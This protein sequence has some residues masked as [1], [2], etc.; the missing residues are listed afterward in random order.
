MNGRPTCKPLQIRLH[1]WLVAI[2]ATSFLAAQARAEAVAEAEFAR[3][4]LVLYGTSAAQ[5]GKPPMFPVDSMVTTVLQSHLEWIG[6][7]LDY[8]DAGSTQPPD[9]QANVRAIIVDGSLHVAVDR[10][11]ALVEWLTAQKKHGLP[12][13]LLGGLPVES[14]QPL[15]RFLA[16]FGIGGGAG[17]EHHLKEVSLAVGDGSVVSH[18]TELKARTTG[19]LN[20]LAPSNG[21]ALLSVL[22]GDA[23]GGEHRFDAVFTAPWGMAWMSPYVMLEVGANRRF[24]YLDPFR[25]IQTWLGDETFPAPDTTTQSGRRLFFSHIDGD[26]FA[27]RS[28]TAGGKICAEVMRDRV[29]KAHDLPVTVSVIEA[30]VC[31]LTQSLSP[32]NRPRYEEIARSIFSLPNVSPA[33]HSYSH[34]FQW[35]A[36]DPNPGRY[37]AGS[38]ALNEAADYKTISIEREVRGSV[39]YINSTLLPSGKKVEIMLWSGNC[40][41]GIEAL[42]LTRELGIENMNGGDTVMSRMYPSLSAVAP[43]LVPWGDELQIYAANQNEFMYTNGMNG[44]FSSGFANVV[45][46]FEST[47]SPR[48]LKPINLYYHFYSAASLSAMRALEKALAWCEKQALHGITAAQ[49]AR[50]VRDAHS[51]Q[52]HRIE[53]GKWRLVSQGDL[54]TWRLPASAGVPDIARCKN[55]AG[56][57]AEGDVTYVHTNGGREA[58]LV[59]APPSQPV[60]AYLHLRDAS[61]PILLVDQKARRLSFTVGGRS[62]GEMVIAG[63]P[64]GATCQLTR[65]DTPNAKPTSHAADAYGCVTLTVPSG[66]QAEFAVTRDVAVR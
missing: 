16:E 36:A 31:G 57:K 7:E 6:Y 66:M 60:A 64:P 4:I 38:L 12:I 37:E 61:V 49:Y 41:P 5:S 22:G 29:L 59:L 32:D 9:P 28:K 58:I 53:P 1:V 10:E 23:K 33:S 51:S 50:I 3:R 24:Y 19:F 13:L 11:D 55:I 48:R 17:A 35:D 34:P 45:D 18:E 26:G 39:N 65:L 21:K 15:A 52:V 43:R 2:C 8:C 47:G 14:A 40:R 54:Q 62:T 20:L 46:T 44:P 25:M 27:S 63:A 30:E 42:R 56:Y